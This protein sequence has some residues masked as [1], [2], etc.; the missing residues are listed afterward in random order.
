MNKEELKN[1][2]IESKVNTLE[3]VVASLRMNKPIKYLIK[4]LDTLNY[5]IN[6]RL[7]RYSLKKNSKFPRVEFYC[8][9]Q[10]AR[11]NTHSHIYLKVP[12]CYDYE[13]VVKLMKKEFIKLDHRKKPKFEIHSDKVRNEDYYAIYSARA[14]KNDDTDTFVAI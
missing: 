14:F 7:N 11:N 8:F 2:L 5:A 3:C 12:S 1:E 10:Y 6:Y 13:E 9:N 4:K